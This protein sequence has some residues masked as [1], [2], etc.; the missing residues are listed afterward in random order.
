MQPGVSRIGPVVAHHPHPAGRHHDVERALRGLGARDQVRLLVQGDSVDRDV[1][2]RVTADNVIVGDPY[3]PLD[4]VGLTW[5]GAE[6]LPDRPEER[7]ERHVIEPGERFVTGGYRRSG[8]REPRSRAVEHHDVAAADRPDPVDDLVHQ[9]LVADQQRVLH[10][11][12]RD[13]ERLHHEGLDQQRDREGDREEHHHLGD[14]RPAAAGCLSG[15]LVLLVHIT[16]FLGVGRW[17]RSVATGPRQAGS[18]RPAYRGSAAWAGDHVTSA[19][20]VVHHHHPA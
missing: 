17:R 1:A 7:P 9:D 13:E 16:G 3:H 19:L 4:V 14:E 15:I 12:R 6:Q 20:L 10:R 11:G 2:L 5:R 18:P 8:R